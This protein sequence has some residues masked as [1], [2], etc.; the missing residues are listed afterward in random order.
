MALSCDLSKVFLNFYNLLEFN[1]VKK[2]LK[3]K[4]KMTLKIVATFYS[5]IEICEICLLDK[6][7]NLMKYKSSKLCSI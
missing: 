5:T 7:F 3:A 1:I 4:N 6:I 2:I